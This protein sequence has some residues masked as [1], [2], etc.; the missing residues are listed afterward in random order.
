EDR[1]PSTALRV[2]ERRLLARATR[3]ARAAPVEVGKLEASCAEVDLVGEDVEP[4]VRNGVGDVEAE[5]IRHDGDLRTRVAQAGHQVTQPWV[6]W[7]LGGDPP[8]RG[9]VAGQ[10]SPLLLEAFAATD[11]AAEVE[12]LDLPPGEVAE[13]IEQVDAHVRLGDGAVEVE[14]DGGV[15]EVHHRRTI[16]RM[17][18][19]MLTRSSQTPRQ[20]GW[21]PR[22][23]PTAPAAT[24]AGRALQ[25]TWLGYLAFA[26]WLSAYGP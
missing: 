14:E 3:R 17:T 22:R 11:G 16:A 7:H 9:L 10:Q 15:G 23:R 8:Q 13:P 19:D 4:K 25:L 18:T 24:G 26:I 12:V 5:A 20:T 2:L 1:L 6:E 21:R